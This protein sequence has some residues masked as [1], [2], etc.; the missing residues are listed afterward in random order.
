MVNKVDREYTTMLRTIKALGDT[1]QSRNSEVRS[2]INLSTTFYETPLISIRTTA[3]K[4]ALKEFEWFMS[5]SNNVLDLDVSVRHWWTPFADSEGTINN[6]YG[7]QFRYYNGY[8]D[9]IETLVNGIIKDPYSRRNIITTWQ[10]EDMNN[11]I[12][13]ITNCHGTNIAVYCRPEGALK[14]VM[15]QRSADMLLGVPH[16]W[17]QYWAFGLWL[18]AQTDR[19]L[20]SFDWIGLDCHIYKDHLDAAQELITES[21][22]AKIETPTLVYK[23][24][25][26]DVFKASDFD[27]IGKYTPVIKTKLNMIV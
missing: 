22:K 13:S 21:I 19:T 3:W 12:T 24:K 15:V 17:I 23:G 20:D 4:N 8:Y 10:T 7:S 16:N 1:V 27:I 2:F 18:A 11:P 14:L 26:G 5:G 6:S 9:Q 25:K